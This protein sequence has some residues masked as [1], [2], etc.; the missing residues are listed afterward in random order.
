M[1]I[2]GKVKEKEE[3]KKEYEKAKREGRQAVIGTIDPR[4]K[5]IMT[6]EIGNI[7]PETEFTV[8]ISFIQ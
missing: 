5:D 8:F 3:A 4:S 7:P 1:S 2:E 6:L